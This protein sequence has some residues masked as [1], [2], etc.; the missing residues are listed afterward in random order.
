MKMVVTERGWRV[1]DHM[2][3]VKPEAG[4]LVG[5]SSAIGD[6]E[7]SFDKPGSSF[8]W[9]GDDYH[10]NR[11]EV[12]VLVTALQVWLDDGRLPEELSNA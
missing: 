9:F 6:Y 3:Y 8:L 11:D 2:K 12:R 1:V 5:E 10:L 7:D 4:R